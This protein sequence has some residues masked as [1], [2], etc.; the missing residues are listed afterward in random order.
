M[1]QDFLVYQFEAVSIQE[2]IMASFKLKEMVG[3]SQLLETLTDSILEQV[4]G[5]VG[6]NVLP[7]FSEPSLNE[8]SIYFPRQSGGVFLAVMRNSDKA[9]Q[10][11]DL[12]P[13]V[14][15]TSVPG[16]KFSVANAVNSNIKEAFSQVRESLNS[17]K[18][19]PKISLPELT[20]IC[21][22]SPRTGGAVYETQLDNGNYISIDYPTHVKNL[23]QNRAKESFEKVTKKW[24]PESHKNMIFPNVFDHS[25]EA[26]NE[27][28]FPF[29]GKEGEHTIAIVHA[30]G[31]G[32]GQFIRDFFNQLNTLDDA[33]FLAAYAVFSKGMDNA[34][35]KAAQTAMKWLIEK[36]EN[37]NISALPIRPLILSGD[38]VTCIIHSDYAFG[39]MQKLTH[40]FEEESKYELDKLLEIDKTAR[41][42]FKEYLTMTTGMVF[43]RSNQPFYMGYQLAESLCSH[44]KD[45][46]RQYQSKNGDIAPSLLSFV[47]STSTLF[48]EAE[49]YF[50][51]EMTTSKGTRLTQSHYGFGKLSKPENIKDLVMLKDLQALS[52]C[53]SSDTLNISVVREIAT[54]LQFDLNHAER[55]IKR[56][57][58]LKSPQLVSFE[59]S[60]VIFGLDSLEAL[61]TINNPISDLIAYQGI[62]PIMLDEGEK[63]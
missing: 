52:N 48:E 21:M 37:R 30:D 8:D 53:F 23:T 61:L 44:A 15:Q 58:E 34:T 11:I 32:I 35:Q 29:S 27:T 13:L 43:L 60:L 42:V 55:L 49:D 57:R 26:E 41:D 33:K 47:H 10:F 63:R 1:S 25:K 18:N 16:L 45:K 9:N 62:N 28:H 56:W 12:W 31:N 40:S 39:F 46:G 4:V 19:A 6:L 36:T 22:R 50:K 7:E 59:Q 5:T 17:E 20:P 54:Y 38:D 3:A 24:L 2:Y 51:T 14:V